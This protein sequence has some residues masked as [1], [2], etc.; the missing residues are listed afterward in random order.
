MAYEIRRPNVSCAAYPAAN[1]ADACKKLVKQ[2]E[3]LGG[4]TFEIWRVEK[5]G[6]NVTESREATYAHLDI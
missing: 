1:F 4:G 5:R 3:L 6:R 2:A